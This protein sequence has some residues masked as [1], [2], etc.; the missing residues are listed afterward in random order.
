M[1]AAAVARDISHL[2][3]VASLRVECRAAAQRAGGPSVLVA[4]RDPE[5][6]QFAPDMNAALP[7]DQSLAAAC[8]VARGVD[9]W[10]CREFEGARSLGSDA[11]EWPT[12]PIPR[13]AVRRPY[14]GAA[15]RCVCKLVA[16]AVHPLWLSRGSTASDLL[17][18]LDF[19]SDPVLIGLAEDVSLPRT[20]A[21]AAVC[22]LRQRFDEARTSGRARTRGEARCRLLK[23]SSRSTDTGPAPGWRWAWCRRCLRS[24]AWR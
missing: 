3:R 16:T 4:V 19:Y 14:L 10:I 22:I 12:G 6:D 21:Q 17:D 15:E 20:Q 11:T 7:Q 23:T 9:R 8:E 2:L 1:A 5:P 13:R 18:Q 24:C